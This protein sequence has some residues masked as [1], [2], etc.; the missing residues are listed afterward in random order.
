MEEPVDLQ[1]SIQ[2]TQIRVRLLELQKKLA[3]ILKIN[4][5]GRWSEGDI[6][7]VGRF[8]KDW[9]FIAPPLPQVD[10][11]SNLVSGE[12]RVPPWVKKSALESQLLSPTI[13]LTILNLNPK[14]VLAFDELQVWFNASTSRLGIVSFASQGLSTDLLFSL[15][16]VG[17][18]VGIQ[19][20]MTIKK[21]EI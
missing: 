17:M 5:A 18:Q 1:R 15:N 13:Q 7:N 16:V 9:E 12:Q 14:Y 8:V 19:S 20:W 3:G 6:L 21:T 10:R 11:E 4:V 2:V